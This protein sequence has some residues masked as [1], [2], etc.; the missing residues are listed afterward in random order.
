MSRGRNWDHSIATILHS[1]TVFLSSDGGLL[2]IGEPYDYLDASLPGKSACFSVDGRLLAADGHE[3]QRTSCPRFFQGRS[4]AL[5]SDGNRLAIG[6]PYNSDIELESGRVQVY[7]WSGGA[8]GQMGSNIYG[9]ETEEYFGASVSMSADGKWL[10]AGA[11]Y[12]NDN[13]EEAGE[14][15]VSARLDNG[16]KQNSSI[17]RSEMPGDHFGISVSL[18]ED[19]ERLAVGARQLNTGAGFARVFKVINFIALGDSYASG[20]GAKNYGDTDVKG[21]NECHRSQYVWSGSEPGKIAEEAALE[22]R[23]K[24]KFSLPWRQNV[25]CHG[26]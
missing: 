17:I 16:W 12:N 7:Q 15:R 1:T 3:H 25:Q 2:A 8:W 13:G 6:A 9:K 23:K 22:I 14:V 26:G 11:P 20:T 21:V 18:S 24:G 10:A 5:S 19:G 4:I